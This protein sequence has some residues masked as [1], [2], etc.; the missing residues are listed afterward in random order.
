MKRSILAVDDEPYMRTVI[1]LLL[2]GLPAELRLA[3][4]AEEALD[5]I[6]DRPPTL[7]VSDYQLPGMSGLELL[8][9][10]R[11]RWPGVAVI[12]HTGD[13]C[14][15]IGVAQRMGIPVVEKG[16]APESLRA[17]V[18]AALGLASRADARGD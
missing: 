6:R 13:P 8:E 11:E 15:V 16:G 3:A 9:V 5:A 10:V 4:C 1:R 12:L 2:R 18:V 14:A 17:A 7:L